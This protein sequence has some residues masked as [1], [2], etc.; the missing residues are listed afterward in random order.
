MPSQVKYGTGKRGRKMTDEI[1]REG[2][3]Q[4]ADK[5]FAFLEKVVNPPLE[6]LGG[7]LADKIKLWRWKNQ[8]NIIPQAKR[9]CEQKE[10][11]LGKIPLK[12]LAPLLEHSSWEENP[13]MQTKWASLLANA[14]N[15]NYS[16]DIHPTYVEILNQL[17]S[18]ETKL[19]D[20]LFNE[21]ERTFADKKHVLLFSKEKIC[22][23]MNIPSEK[24][25]I[26]IDNLFRLNLLQPPASYD[27]ISI[28][29]YPIVLRTHEV[30]QLTPLGRDF[31]RHCRFP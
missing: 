30:I 13:D 7:L 31:V 9:F 28:G 4:L 22:Q 1:A 19:L 2:I 5:A 18:L 16:Y 12:T 26:L 24:L 3:N 8:V 27:G 6:E 17:S 11:Q 10:I 29:K 14:A 20:S 23:A 25:D 15:P 21:Y